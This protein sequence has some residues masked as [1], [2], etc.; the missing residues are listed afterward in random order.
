MRRIDAEQLEVLDEGRVDPLEGRL[1][2]Q[3]LELHLLAFVV[4]PLAVLDGPAGLDRA[5]CRPLA[6]S[7]RM[8]PEPSVF[9]GR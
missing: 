3:D 1:E 9:G 8:L 2:I 5:A 6:S 4:H 7:S